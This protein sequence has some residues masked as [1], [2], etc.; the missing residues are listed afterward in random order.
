VEQ[1]A[2]VTPRRA[3]R[4]ITRALLVLGGA[5]AASAAAWALS[6]TTA[7]ADPL[8]LPANPVSSLTTDATSTTSADAASAD[9]TSAVNAVTGSAVTSSDVA[10]AVDPAVHALHQVTTGRTPIAMPVAAP[11]LPHPPADLGAVAEQVR[12]TVSGGTDLV[13]DRLNPDL[14]TADQ[15]I[16][17]AATLAHPAAHTDPMAA[18]PDQTAPRLVSRS[19]ARP[20]FGP[21]GPARFVAGPTVRPTGSSATAAA[22]ADRSADES[23]PTGLSRHLPPLFPLV[24]PSGS[25][26]SG[27][28]HVATGFPGGPGANHFVV[29]RPTSTVSAAA[30][31]VDVPPRAVAPGSQPGTTPD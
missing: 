6:S 23:W 8:A 26:D 31:T 25:S 16:P 19:A 28:A 4:L 1:R 27:G 2:E 3:R 9:A 15:L 12:S 11:Q 20:W 10:G 24:P 30:V 14:P 13:G 18:A 5:V 17:A 29:E 21:A 7:S 22:V